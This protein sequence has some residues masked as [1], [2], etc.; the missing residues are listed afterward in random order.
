[1]TSTRKQGPIH[2]GRVTDPPRRLPHDGRRAIIYL[3]ISEDDIGAGLGVERQEEDARNYAER[4]GAEVIA[5]IVDN[6]YSASKYA[7]KVRPGYRELMK[8]IN[9]GEASMI[10][11]YNIDRLYRQPRELEDLI[12]RCELGQI[13]IGSM[14]GELDLN[15]GDHRAWARILVTMAAKES[16][17][18]SRRKRR[19]N[20]Q[21]RERGIPA[22]PRS[23]GW[24]DAMRQ[25]PDEAE[26][27]RRIVKR[28][29]AGDSLYAIAN[30]LTGRGVAGKNGGEFW[31]VATVKQLL[32]HPR[33]YGLVS[34]LEPTPTAERPD[35]KTLRIIRPGIFDGI[36]PAEQYEEVQSLLASRR[37]QM[38]PRKTALL[39]NLVFCFTCGQPLRR[40]QHGHDKNRSML[41]CRAQYQKPG[42]PGI[43]ID[44]DLVEDH[45]TKAVFAAVDNADLAQMAKDDKGKRTA[46]Q[47]ARQLAALEARAD[48][49]ADRH[50]LAD[51][52][53]KFLDLDA[54]GRLAKRIKAER[55]DLHEKIAELST[56]AALRPYAGKAGALEAKWES[57]TL[58][59]KREIVA[60]ALE[61]DGVRIVVKPVPPENRDR[62]RPLDFER[63]RVTLIKAES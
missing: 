25:E 15:D 36:C 26:E 19:E 51:D 14:H 7:K 57:L 32:Q 54:Y 30:D 50:L 62:A 28:F 61:L 2:H 24:I 41:V 11:C 39:T 42:C 27:V 34:Y 47:L 10:I 12:A 37:R 55:E 38:R 49:A 33:N 17:N 16:D 23:F 31:Q 48:E 5:V 46:A 53:D 52:D 18:T 58:P 3:R 40:N 21:T 8:L 56:A 60:E 29:L 22:A 6:D 63:G 13:W 44:A 20:E 35:K 1:M 59:I 43:T 4:I 9:A 45:I